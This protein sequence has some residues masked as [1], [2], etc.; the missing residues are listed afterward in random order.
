MKE[1]VFFRMPSDLERS[2]AAISTIREYR[3]YRHI[4]N[5]TNY[6]L[7][8]TVAGRS[9]AFAQRI[10]IEWH[11]ADT[12]E[13]PPRGSY[14]LVF[15]FDT[16]YE[17]MYQWS[18]P[19]QKHMVQTYGM[20]LAIDPPAVPDLS[21]VLERK[22]TAPLVGRLLVDDR[23]SYPVDTA[24]YLN[25]EHAIASV[26]DGD[27]V[28]GLRDGFTYL[29]CAM[30]LPVVE[31]YPP[32]RHRRWISKWSHPLYAMIYSAPEHVRSETIQA[33][34]EATWA[35]SREVRQESKTPTARQ[36][37]IAESVVGL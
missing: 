16:P 35:R 2:I 21:V 14:D 4:A 23:I 3:R 9:A 12:S 37:S 31:I 29:A 17:E 20:Q 25:T 32:D 13:L 1:N 10:D 18:L 33:A 8:I 36:P 27:V 24:R 30:G 19:T 28:V 15:D 26:Q 22:A 7:E 5:K 11:L 34:V 6:E